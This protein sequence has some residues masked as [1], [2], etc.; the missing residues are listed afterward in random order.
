M[1]KFYFH[2][3]QP[4]YPRYVVITKSAIRVYESKQK[5]LSLYGKPIIAIPLAAVRKVERIKF[6]LT[7]DSRFEN[8]E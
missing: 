8:S 4:Y 2:E 7:D 6:D 3:F 5:S 1:S